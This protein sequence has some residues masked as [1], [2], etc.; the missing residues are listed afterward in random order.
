LAVIPLLFHSLRRP[1][2]RI[3]AAKGGPPLIISGK[4]S[5]NSGALARKGR[6]E[7]SAVAALQGSTS[8][9]ERGL[10]CLEAGCPGHPD[11]AAGL[12]NA[13]P[14]GTGTH[15]RDFAADSL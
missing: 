4:N 10:Q 11:A 14:G 6:L 3:S 7:R 15:R 1:K 9:L 5:E 2:S 8:G 13:V 12:Y